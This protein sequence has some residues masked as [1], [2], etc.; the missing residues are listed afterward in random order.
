MG[1]KNSLPYDSRGDWHIDNS[2]GYPEIVFGY[3]ESIGP[4]RL[5]SQDTLKFIPTRKPKGQ[6]SPDNLKQELQKRLSNIQKQKTEIENS[7]IRNSKGR[8]VGFRNSEEKPFPQAP[9][10]PPAQ[11]SINQKAQQINTIKQQIPLY[12]SQLIGC[13][14]IRSKLEDLHRE[15]QQ[16]ESSHGGRRKT[17][18]NR[19]QKPRRAS[20]A[21]RKR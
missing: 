21:S 3:Y 12:E 6:Q 11:P 9:V 16:L 14:V 7:T 15:L 1:S 19:K 17:R 18:K 5:G 2:R 8:I 10:T 4:G 20:T 13:D